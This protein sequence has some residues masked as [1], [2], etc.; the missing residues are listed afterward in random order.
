MPT[1]DP[2]LYVFLVFRVSQVLKKLKEKGIILMVFCTSKSKNTV[3]FPV[4]AVPVLSKE[5]ARHKEQDLRPRH[6]SCGDDACV[7]SSN[8]DVIVE[9]TNH[10]GRRAEAKRRKGTL[11]FMQRSQIS[12]PRKYAEALT[13]DPAVGPHD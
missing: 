6:T 12:F 11:N 9:K 13:A 7:T 5:V 1:P 4:P 2:H 10:C 8:N 3:A